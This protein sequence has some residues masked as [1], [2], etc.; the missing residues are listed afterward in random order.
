MI[1]RPGDRF[2]NSAQTLNH[3]NMKDPDAGQILELI[4][5]WISESEQSLSPFIYPFNDK[6]G[7]SVL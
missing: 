3:V 4:K 1:G 6:V 5:P 2:R 7:H